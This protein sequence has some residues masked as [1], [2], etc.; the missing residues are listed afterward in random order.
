VD[1]NG[2]GMRAGATTAGS[3]GGGVVHCQWGFLED[4]GEYFHLQRNWLTTKQK[5]NAKNKS[6]GE[7]L[8]WDTKSESD[9]SSLNI[10]NI[11]D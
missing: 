3:G 5:C 7:D 10:Q 1:A 4:S 2:P 11:A 9:F 8:F 6:I